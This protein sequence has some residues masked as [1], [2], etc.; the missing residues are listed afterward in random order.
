[1]PAIAIANSIFWMTKCRR[2]PAVMRIAA[3]T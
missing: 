3:N 2:M 1:M